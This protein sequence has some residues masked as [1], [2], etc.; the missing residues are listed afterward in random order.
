[1]AMA[2]SAQFPMRM[3]KMKRRLISCDSWPTHHSP[4]LAWFPF[5][6]AWHP[7]SSSVPRPRCLPEVLF[8]V[9]VGCYLKQG[10]ALMMLRSLRRSGNVHCCDWSLM[11]PHQQ[12]NLGLFLEVQVGWRTCHQSGGGW[13]GSADQGESWCKGNPPFPPVI[14]AGALHLLLQ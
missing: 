5:W 14:S 7:R 3:M 9:A 2:V 4:P 11:T 1:M 8:S 12:L 13:G 10:R 6:A